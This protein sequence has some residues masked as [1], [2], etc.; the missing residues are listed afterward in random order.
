MSALAAGRRLMPYEDY[1]ALPSELRAE[2]VDGEVVM[3][4]SP[5]YA[6]QQVSR[7]LANTLEAALTG[8][9]VVEAITVTILPGR[10]RIPDISVVRNAPAP[11]GHLAE[12]PLVVV[13]ILSASTR[14]EDLVRKSTEYLAAPVQQ[15]WLVEPLEGT[16]EVY[17][18]SPTGWV[19]VAELDE[20]HPSAAVTVADVGTVQLNR[21]ELFAR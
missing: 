7:R 20:R 10:E 6:H 9:F 11:S 15:Y 21:A 14:T 8:V 19:R 2:W 4:P 16:V 13:E 17:A 18:N 3:N 1:L 12:I 5:S